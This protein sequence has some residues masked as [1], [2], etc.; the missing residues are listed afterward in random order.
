MISRTCLVHTVHEWSGGLTPELVFL[1]TFI[2][3][4]VDRGGFSVFFT[5]PSYLGDKIHIKFSILSIQI[6]GI[7]YINVVQ[8]QTSAISRTFSIF[9]PET[10][11]I[12]SPNSP[13]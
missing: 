9:P 11:Y 1:G 2:V 4:E 3:F 10:V 5:L 6:C 8:P 12:P 7:M 13:W